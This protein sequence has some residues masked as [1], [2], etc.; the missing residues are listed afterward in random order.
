MIIS[1]EGQKSADLRNSNALIHHP[2]IQAALRDLLLTHTGHR[3]FPEADFKHF[4]V[5]LIRALPRNNSLYF[6]V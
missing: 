5:T 3:V 2:T 6:R 4:A 1:R